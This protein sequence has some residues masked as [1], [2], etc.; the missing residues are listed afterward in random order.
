MA[1][2][3]RVYVSP[4]LYRLRE[5]RGSAVVEFPM[6]ATLLLMVAFASIQLGLF[7]HVSNSL[8]DAAVQGAHEAALVGSD[9]G[10][11]IKKTQTVV[12]GRFGE[13]VNAEV[14][15]ALE[16]NSSVAVAVDF[17]APILGFL[18]PD[19]SM[20]VVGHAILEQPN[21]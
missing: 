8:T 5:E 7:I 9:L 3:Y 13:L 16:R 10:R 20:R 11:G 2:L 1:E 14:S 19:R 4:W 12:N 21:L 6:V 18:G 17:N 15:G